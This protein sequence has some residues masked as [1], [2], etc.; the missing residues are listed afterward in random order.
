MNV[1]F[2]LFARIATR[3]GEIVEEPGAPEVLVTIYQGACAQP[4]ARYLAAMTKVDDATTRVNNAESGLE[5]LLED[6]DQQF[7]IARSA[8]G[9]MLPDTK[10]P[11]TLKSQTTDTDKRKAIERLVA[12][13]TPHAGQPWA[14]TLLQGKF[15]QTAAV[16]IQQLNE[17]IEAQNALQKAKT[18]RAGS[19]DAAWSAYMRFKRLVRNTLGSTSRQYRRIHVRAASGIEEEEETSGPTD[20]GRAPP[21]S[22]PASGAA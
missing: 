14:D 5:R 18:D 10:L 20:A 22:A 3:C 17:S 6:M 9:A 4:L 2:A 16:A 1:E 11:A 12:L 7:R 19:F 8:V 13:I 15:G 21:A